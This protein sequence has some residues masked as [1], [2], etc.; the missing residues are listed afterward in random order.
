MQ[1]NLQNESGLPEARFGQ[2]KFCEQL[3]GSDA[4]SSR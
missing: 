3:Q 1:S 2:L 4:N